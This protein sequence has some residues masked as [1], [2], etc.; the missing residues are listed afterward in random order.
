MKE[1]LQTLKILAFV[2]LI[3]FLSSRGWASSRD[4]EKRAFVIMEGIDAAPEDNFDVTY[5]LAAPQVLESG[6]GEGGGG[7]G[8]KESLILQKTRCKTLWQGHYFIQSKVEHPLFWGHLQTLVLGEEMARR[9]VSRVTDVFLRTAETRRKAWV[10]VADGKADKILEAAPK[11]EKLPSL[12]IRRA[13]ETENYLNMIPLIR[14]AEFITCLTSP[15]EQAV[16]PIVKADQESISVVGLALFEED[17]M[18]G[19]LDY[20]EMHYF[21]LTAQASGFMPKRFET[22]NGDGFVYEIT[23]AKRRIKPHRNGNQ[24][25]FTVSLQLEGNIIESESQ[26]SLKDPEFL[27]EAEQAVSTALEKDCRA[28]LRKVQKEFKVDSYCFGAIVRARY[29]QLWKEINW[30]EEFPNVPIK[31][32][33]DARIRRLGMGAK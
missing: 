12:Y 22:A 21:F 30:T 32:T 27:R 24:I 10:T 5:S 23:D 31:I 6:G 15:G 13:L 16:A 26:R 28:V 14:V 25:S 3:V 4:I 18:V 11:T 1:K 19:K 29:P 20:N 7:G 17:K 2:L 8:G 33:V 9:G